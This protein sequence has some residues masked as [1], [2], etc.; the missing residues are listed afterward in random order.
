MPDAADIYGRSLSFPPRVGSDGRMVWSSGE[1]NI[2]ESIRLILMTDP[3]ER[4]RRPDFGGGLQPLLFEPNTA[5]RHR[6]LQDRIQ[7]A[8]TRWEPRITVE[9][10]QVGIDPENREGAIVTLNYRLVA[11]QARERISLNLAPPA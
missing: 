9:S 6:L 4:L 10:I 2:R 3:G 8:L 1:Q 11:T 7:A 5:S